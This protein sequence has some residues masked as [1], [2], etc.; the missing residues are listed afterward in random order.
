[1]VGLRW[2]ILLVSTDDKGRHDTSES[3]TTQ[4]RARP[5]LPLNNHIGSNKHKD[6]RDSQGAH[7]TNPRL[8]KLSSHTL[9][10]GIKCLVFQRLA[11]QAL[12]VCRVNQFGC[13][14]WT[15]LI[16]LLKNTWWW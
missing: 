9:D 12:C 8:L 11:M 14:T 2:R 10:I 15:N 1:M 7:L 13:R 16:V 4:N 3:S 5:R 6:Y